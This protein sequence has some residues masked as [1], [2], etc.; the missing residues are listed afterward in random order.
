M[1][2]IVF[3][4]FGCNK[5]LRVL[6]RCNK[7]YMKDSPV[8]PPGTDHFARKSFNETQ[9]THDK[10]TGGQ[11][12]IPSPS[13][14]PLLAL[15]CGQAVK[16]YL[17]ED[18]TQSGDTSFVSILVDTPITFSQIAGAAPISIIE[19][20]KLPDLAVTVTLD[21]KDLTKGT[22]PLNVTKHPLSFSLSFTSPRTKAYNLSCTAKTPDGQT[23]SSTSLFTFLP[24]KPKGIGSVTKMDMRTGALLARPATGNGGP[25]ERVFPI[26][27]YT[28]F[29]SFLAKNLS[30]IKV[31]KDQG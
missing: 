14:K 3:V 11:F 30:A 2:S 17:P 1:V 20:S 10:R 31:L 5:L 24:A 25:Y 15:R 9:E 29:D 28:Q 22:V 8:E 6:C 27:F 26:G 7:N 13:E 21:G 19:N 12:P 18:S 4:P 23:F 16:P